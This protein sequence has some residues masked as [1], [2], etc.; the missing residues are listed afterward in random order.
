MMGRL[1]TAGLALLTVIVSGLIVVLGGTASSA[2][3]TAGSMVAVLGSMAG[4][5]FLIFRSVERDR[6]R[7]LT[8][9]GFCPRCRRGIHQSYRGGRATWVH[10]IGNREECWKPP[11]HQHEVLP[12]PIS[13]GHPR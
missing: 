4:A 2:L 12:V 7:L 10:N 5:G 1:A 8:T 11:Y 6:A 3:I 9:P 13:P